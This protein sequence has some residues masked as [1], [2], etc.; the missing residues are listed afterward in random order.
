MKNETDQRLSI[1]KEL[2]Q[3]QLLESQKDLA[4]KEK[5]LQELRL[6]LQRKEEMISASHGTSN[7]KVVSSGTFYG[8]LLLTIILGSLAAYGMFFSKSDNKTLASNSSLIDSTNRADSA[9]QVSESR[10]AAKKPVVKKL[11]AAQK[12][13]SIRKAELEKQK[14]ST[15]I[16]DTT[17]TENPPATETENDETEKSRYTVR[18][19]AF[20][21]DQP[22]ESTRREA[23]IVSWNNA[24]LTPLEEKDGFIYVVF[25]NHLGQTSKG[26]LRKQDLVAVK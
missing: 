9:R 8:L 4:F 2:L 14:N 11:S 24:R 12:R 5:E 6:R 22:D 13:D 18:S 19:K 21:H 23:F 25:T 15:I 1:Q 17:V 16:A 3:Q 26:W 20:F 10:N 7:K